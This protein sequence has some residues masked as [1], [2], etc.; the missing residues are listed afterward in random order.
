MNTIVLILM[1]NVTNC[2]FLTAPSSADLSDTETSS[3]NEGTIQ[4]NSDDLTSESYS[5]SIEVESDE[6]PDF[7]ASL[8]LKFS[9]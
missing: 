6:S 8:D 7:N 9:R 4:C 2:P 3:H 5:S 1:K